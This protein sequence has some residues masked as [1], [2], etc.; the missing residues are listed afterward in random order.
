MSQDQAII[1]NLKAIEYD[2]RALKCMAGI[3]AELLDSSIGTTTRYD[4]HSRITISTGELDQLCFAW[5]DV[6]VRSEKLEREFMA[7]LYPQAME[8]GAA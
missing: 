8:D 5:N 2:F 7:R 6:L 3:L 1:E 4:E